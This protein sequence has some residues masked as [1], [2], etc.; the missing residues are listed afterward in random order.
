MNARQEQLLALFREANK[1]ARQLV[2]LEPKLEGLVQDAGAIDR[3]GS[4]ISGFADLIGVVAD[5]CHALAADLL[6]EE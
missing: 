3:L 6:D 5:R 2:E 1:H 4:Q